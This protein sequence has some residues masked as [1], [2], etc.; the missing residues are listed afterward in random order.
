METYWYWII[1]IVCIAALL[2]LSWLIYWLATRKSSDSDSAATTA[3]GM[4]EGEYTDEQAA[5]DNAAAVNPVTGIPLVNVR[6]A[7]AIIGVEAPLTDSLTSAGLPSMQDALGIVSGGRRRARANTGL[8]TS[9]ILIEAANGGVGAPAII[10][11]A[12]DQY[13]APLTP[14]A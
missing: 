5:A 6:P 14:A 1:A 10:G 9:P 13:A 11:T 4:V 2:L 8:E 12:S 3:S 7:S